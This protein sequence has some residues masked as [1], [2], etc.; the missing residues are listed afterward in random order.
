MWC[1]KLFS[2]DKSRVFFFQE[3]FKLSFWSWLS[4]INVTVYLLVSS[5]L[6]GQVPWCHNT[7]RTGKGARL[8]GPQTDKSSVT[9]AWYQS[10]L[11]WYRMKF[12]FAVHLRTHLYPHYAD[13]RWIWTWE[14]VQTSAG[15]SKD[16]NYV[17]NKESLDVSCQEPLRNV[18]YQFQGWPLIQWCLPQ[19]IFHNSGLLIYQELHVSSLNHTHW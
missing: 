7:D 9:S 11:L 19:Q 2:S 1:T 18:I 6:S 15:G 13:T 12:V 4:T 16:V 10:L 5:T 3:I 17:P 14:G 8:S